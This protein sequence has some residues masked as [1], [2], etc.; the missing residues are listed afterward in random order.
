[1]QGIGAV[2]VGRRCIGAHLEQQIQ[3]LDFAANCKISS[4]VL[5]EA[6]ITVMKS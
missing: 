4:P 3:A 1:M 2:D 5:I 6:E